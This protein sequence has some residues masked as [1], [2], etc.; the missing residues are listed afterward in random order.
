VGTLQGGGVMTMDKDFK[1]KQKES[2][3]R[4]FFLKE[5]I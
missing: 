4:I 2:K 3:G 1:E 5:V